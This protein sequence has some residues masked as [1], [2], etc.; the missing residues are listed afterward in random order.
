MYVC[1]YIY[2]DIYRDIFGHPRP[3]PGSAKPSSSMHRCICVIHICIIYVHICIDR[4]IHLGR[5]AHQALLLSTQ[6]CL[7]HPHLHHPYPYQHQPIHPSRSRL[8]PR[9]PPRHGRL[10]SS[11]LSFAPSVPSIQSACTRCSTPSAR[12]RARCGS[13]SSE[14]KGTCGWPLGPI[15]PGS[16]HM[17]AGRCT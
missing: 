3:T 15:K 10:A 1:V 4:S 9:P 16:G 6:M 13:L 17:R 8:A 12:G 7:C 14:V 11:P 5:G 2:I